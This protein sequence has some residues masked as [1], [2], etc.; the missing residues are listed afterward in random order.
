M[1][2]LELRHLGDHEF[3]AARLTAAGLSATE[4]VGKARCFADAAEAL[5]RAG[6]N[7]N[8][9]A[10]AY[11]VPG[12]IEVLGKHT[13]YAGGRTLVAAA[14]RGFCGVAVAREDA[15]IHVVDVASRREAKFSLCPAPTP[16]PGDWCNY[17]ISA[18]RRIARNFPGAERGAS[19]AFVSDLPL[20]A[21][22]SSSSALIVLTFL[23]LADVNQL[24]SHPEFVKHINRREDLAGYLGTVENGQSFGGL[25]GDHGVGTFGGSED[26]TAILCSRPGQW[27]QYSYCPVRHE[28]FVT[29]P[30]DYVLAIASSGVAAEKTGSAMQDY[31]RASRLAAAVA[32]LWR[33]SVDQDVPHL[34]AAVASDTGAADQIRDLLA[35]AQHPEFAASELNPRFEHFLAESEEIIPAV[36]DR[37]DE[38]N[39]IRFGQL[40]DRS[41]ALGAEQLG[42]QIPE[43]ITLAALARDHGAAAASAFGAGFGGSVWSLV[44]QDDVGAF[45]NRWAEA[46]AQR[47]PSSAA[48]AEFFTTRAGPAAFPLGDSSLLQ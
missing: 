17:P 27:V 23:L 9:H 45:L 28:R 1:S 16:K 21:G 22:M 31:N 26:H 14:E 19:I 41:Q 30:S 25:A 12:R 44:R 5:S 42:N 15:K 38:S 4:V 35:T 6:G 10:I 46:Y 24:A 36:P 37:L 39:L 48:R 34:A 40:V 3:V 2:P 18:A 32:E 43:T 8:D 7:S 47:F 29:M 11:F 13:D 33:G 20:A